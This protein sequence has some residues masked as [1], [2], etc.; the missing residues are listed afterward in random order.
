MQDSP[1]PWMKRN[2]LSLHGILPGRSESTCIFWLTVTR[3]LSW[4]GSQ[5]LSMDQ[6]YGE[7]TFSVKEW[8]V[9]AK[10][11]IR[12]LPKRTCE[13]IYSFLHCQVVGIGKSYYKA[14]DVVSNGLSELYYPWFPSASTHFVF[15]VLPALSDCAQR[16]SW[17]RTPRVLQLLNRLCGGIQN[18]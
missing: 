5:V 16:S 6:L 8:L 3:R 2:G 12:L 18:A 10:K 14:S 11:L 13:L 7:R 17:R 4:V 15:P 1:R 9:H